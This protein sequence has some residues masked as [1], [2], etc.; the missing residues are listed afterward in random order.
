MKRAAN[1][2]AQERALKRTRDAERDNLSSSDDE[3]MMMVEGAGHED[4][5]FI[6]DGDL[7]REIREQEE[8][9]EELRVH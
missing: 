3:A 1:K 8:Q 4:D 6:N 2:E 9:E 7:T 5:E